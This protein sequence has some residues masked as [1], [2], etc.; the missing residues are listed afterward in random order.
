MGIHI[1][2]VAIEETC[3]DLGTQAALRALGLEEGGWQREGG[4]IY[5]ATLYMMQIRPYAHR[6]HPL[7]LRG[8]PHPRAHRCQERRVLRHVLR[9]LRLRLRAFHRRPHHGR[10]RLRAPG[11]AARNCTPCAQPRAPRARRG[12]RSAEQ[13][14]HWEERATC[15]LFGDGAGAVVLDGRDET[16]AGAAEAA[17]GAAEAAV[18]D[19]PWHP[20]LVH[21]KHRRRRPHPLVRQRLRLPRGTLR[22]RRHD[23]CCRHLRHRCPAPRRCRRGKRSLYAHGRPGGVR[24]SPPP[25]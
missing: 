25:P 13:A 12:R 20:L 22:R 24:S 17:G 21:G 7:P 15:I 6:R 14:R 23:H 3:T 8:R 16:E 11:N 18:L 4:A 19:A 1:R 5:A 2:H 9:L 10:R